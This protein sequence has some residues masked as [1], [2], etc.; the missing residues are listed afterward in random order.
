LF[1]ATILFSSLGVVAIEQT[2]QNENYQ[3]EAGTPN[4]THEL[5]SMT[6]V[7]QDRHN[8]TADNTRNNSNNCSAELKTRDSDADRVND[9]VECSRGTDATVADT[10]GDTLTDA[11]ELHGVT[12]H[13]TPIPESNPREKDIYVVIGMSDGAELDATRLA[14]RFDRLSVEN[15]NG[16]TGINLHYDIQQVNETVRIGNWSK[17]EQKYAPELTRNSEVYRGVLVTTGEPGGYFGKARIYG[18]FAVTQ[19]GNEDTAAHEILHLIV[20]PIDENNCED[21]FHNCHGETLLSS[22]NN[23]DKQLSENTTVHIQQRGLGPHR[24]SW[25]I[26]Y[27]ESSRENA[28]GTSMKKSMTPSSSANTSSRSRDLMSSVRQSDTTGL[29]HLPLHNASIDRE[30]ILISATVTGVQL[31]DYVLCAVCNP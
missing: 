28:N 18:N 19:N 5:D 6:P 20:G 23:D 15:H 7:T 3:F 4:G 14:S 21:V 10:D 22:V 16:N 17:N 30:T 24:D 1:T 2:S 11:E 12:E 26:A 31:D 9:F 29:L 27:S 8:I 25:G 13:G